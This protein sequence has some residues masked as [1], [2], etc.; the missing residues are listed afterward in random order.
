LI[1]VT[2]SASMTQI[3]IWTPTTL[4]YLRLLALQVICWPATHFTLDV[5]VGLGYNADV[6][7]FTL[8]IL[9]STLLRWTTIRPDVRWAV[10]GTTTCVS[11][12][13]D[14]GD[15]QPLALRC[16]HSLSLIVCGR[17]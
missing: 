16:R 12:H 14:M 8:R 7:S 1:G 5:L 2:N 15:K 10:I 6:T 9:E 17:M 13:P 4:L 11:Q 3:N